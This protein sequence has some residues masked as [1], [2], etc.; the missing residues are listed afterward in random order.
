MPPLKEK[1]PQGNHELH[2]LLRE[3]GHV[4]FYILK[5]ILKKFKKLF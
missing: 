1:T 2:A 5:V 4:C 3:I